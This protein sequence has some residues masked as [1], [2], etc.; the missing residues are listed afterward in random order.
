MSEIENQDQTDLFNT[1]NSAKAGQSNMEN[2]AETAKESIGNTVDTAKDNVGNT[3]EAVKNK[4]QDM[5]AADDVIE[6]VKNKLP[7]LTP[8]PPPLHAQATAY[9]LKSRLQWGE[10]GLTILDARD[11]SAFEECHIKGSMLA[12]LEEFEAGNRFNMPLN[13][14][15]YIYGETD[16]ETAKGANTLRQAGFTQVAELKGGLNNWMEIGGATE[17]LATQGHSPA[18][19]ERNVVSRL[20]EFAK[21]KANEKR[22]DQKA[23]VS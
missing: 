3:V 8:T 20:Q 10:P 21:Q 19:S 5:P 23:K 7:N 17:G 13:R 22:M 15:I 12:S 11:R 2:I 9:E 1:E 16:N 4:L 6:K 18:A 14:D